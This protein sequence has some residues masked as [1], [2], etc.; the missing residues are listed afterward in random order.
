[1]SQASTVKGC[2]GCLHANERYQGSSSEL[3]LV[4]GVGGG[5]AGSDTGFAK[6]MAVKDSCDVREAGRKSSGPRRSRSRK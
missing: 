5:H 1:M 4:T 2:S 3:G 6:S